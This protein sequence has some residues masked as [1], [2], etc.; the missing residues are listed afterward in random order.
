MKIYSSTSLIVA[1]MEKLLLVK[2][3]KR[4]TESAANNLVSGSLHFKTKAT[5]I[6]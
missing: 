6:P 5:N 4:E 2:Q 3:W 1:T